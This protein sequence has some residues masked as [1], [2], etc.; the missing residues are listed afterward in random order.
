MAQA[1]PQI[2]D[3]LSRFAQLMLTERGEVRPLGAKRKFAPFIR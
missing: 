1:D 3:V 2:A